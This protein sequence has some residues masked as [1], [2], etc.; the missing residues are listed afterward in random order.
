MQLPDLFE[1]D[2][3]GFITV[4]GSR[5]GLNDIVGLYNDGY[6]AEMIGCEFDTVS[7][8]EIHKVIAFY[9]E[10]KEAVDAYMREEEAE[11]EKLQATTPPGITLVELRRRLEAKRKKAS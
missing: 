3:L 1:K 2:D 8:A 7:L 5:I 11:C 9:L 6:S 4:K 10:N